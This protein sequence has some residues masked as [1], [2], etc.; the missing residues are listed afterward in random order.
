MPE[1]GIPDRQRR[2]IM[3]ILRVDYR[4]SPRTILKAGIQGL[5]LLPET[6]KDSANPSQDFR[7]GSYT[8]F[9]H[10]RSNYSGYDLNI[11]FGIFHTKQEFTT[12]S[13]PSLGYVE[14]FFRIFIG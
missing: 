10:N 8:A 7:R 14:Y 3:P 2:W 6:S 1:R 9:I 4:L 5:P 13:R 12:A 11:L